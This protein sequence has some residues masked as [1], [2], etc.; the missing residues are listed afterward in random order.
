[1]QCLFIQNNEDGSK[2]YLLNYVDDMLYYWTH[3]SGIKRFEELLKQRF[4]V[5][6]MGQAHWYL[7][8]RINQLNNYDVEFDQ[9]RYCKSIMK[10]YLDTAGSKKIL[11]DHPMPL[12]LDFVPTSIDEDALKALEQAYNI[13]YASCIGYLIYLAMTRCDITFTVNKLTK[14]SKRPGKVHFEAMLHV[15]CYLRDNSLVGIKFYSNMMESPITCMLIAENIQQS[16][17]FFTFSESSWNDDVDSGHSTGCFIIVYVGGIIDHSSNLP[18][19]VALSSAKAEYNEGCIAFMATSHLHML[20][21]EME[22]IPESSMAATNV[23]FDSK[24]DIAMG[25]SY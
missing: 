11:N 17:P 18:D 1:M 16:H 12:S 22:G 5:E 19:P 7:A 9:S 20:L 8:T 6:L 3:S 10:K 15:L 14:Y 23:Y 4:N 2:I 24:S 13:D 25:N 21:C